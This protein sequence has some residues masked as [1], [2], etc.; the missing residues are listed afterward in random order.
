VDQPRQ[1]DENGREID[2]RNEPEDVDQW[3]DEDGC[4][5][6]DNDRDTLLDGV[7]KCP[8]DPEDFD[9]FED[10]D[11]CPDKS[12]TTATRCSTRRS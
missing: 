5:D 4:P 10:Q 7:D 2:C 6:P 8:N 9:Q 11:G 3:E 12:T 1:E